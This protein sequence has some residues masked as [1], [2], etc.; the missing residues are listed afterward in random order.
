MLLCYQAFHLQLTFTVH[1]VNGLHAMEF[2]VLEHKAEEKLSLNYLVVRIAQGHLYKAVTQDNHHVRNYRLHYK[3]IL[4]IVYIMCMSGTPTVSG[5]RVSVDE[6]GKAVLSCQASQF[7]GLSAPITFGWF[8]VL[9]QS[10]LVSVRPD[11]RVVNTTSQS[12]SGTE[13]TVFTDKL[14]IG[15]A[16]RFD[17]GAYTC[18][19]SNQHGTSTPSSSATIFVNCECVTCQTDLN[20]LQTTVL[21]LLIPL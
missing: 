7:S 11:S 10:R 12:P 6:G 16:N 8:K 20:G 14:T 2:V 3:R 18:K 19:A 17:A 15:N 5:G 13:E 21:C 9:S 1:G 4:F